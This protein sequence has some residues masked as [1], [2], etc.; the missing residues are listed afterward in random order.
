MAQVKKHLADAKGIPYSSITLVLD[1]KALI[2]PFSLNDIP[3]ARGK[4]EL[5]VTVQLK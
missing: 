4:S 1:G 5:R 2:D 3:A